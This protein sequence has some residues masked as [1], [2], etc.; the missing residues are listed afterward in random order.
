MNLNSLNQ[1]SH[2]FAGF[3]NNKLKRIVN[4][5]QLKYV[6]SVAQG[7]GD[8]L[9]GCFCLLQ[10]AMKNNLQFDINFENHP[11]SQ[12]LEKNLDKDTLINYSNVYR[13][14]QNN[15]EKDHLLFYNGFCRHLNSINTQNYYL[16][17]NSYPIANITQ[18]QREFIK[19][20]IQPNNE[21]VIAVN[22]T[23]KDL[24]L[25][26]VDGQ[27][28][29]YTIHIRTGDKF[30]LQNNKLSPEVANRIAAQ[31]QKY[32]VSSRIYLV[33]SDNSD[34]KAVLINIFPNFKAHFKD[35]TH[36]GESINPPEESVKNTLTDFFL[37]SKSKSIL[38]FSVY[39]HGTSFSEWCAEMYNIP[40]HCIQL[41]VFKKTWSL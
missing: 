13:Y 14:M 10:I 12:F 2:L 20:K 11:I 18:D 3:H 38:S 6:N 21:L 37:M 32:V 41:D 36:L 40:Y 8:Y 24:K 22:K 35:I 30:L 5:Y 9:R 27:P 19:S 29:F 33:L 4:L 28:Y 16:F 7:F 1:H 34:L 31:I 26:I 39:P 17:C 25:K 15:L 23:I